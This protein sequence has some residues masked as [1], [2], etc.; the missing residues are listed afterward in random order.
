MALNRRIPQLDGLRGIAILSVF[1]YHAYNV[2]LMWMGVDL[3][4]VLSGF[5][6]TGILLQAKEQSFKSYIGRFYQRRAR[7]L[8]PGYVTVLAIIGVVFGTA[9]LKHW[10]LYFGLMNFLLP[11]HLANEAINPM[12]SLAVEEQFYF[13]WPVAVFFLSRKQLIRIAVCLLA[14][15]PILRW[16]CTPWFDNHWFVY[17][18]LPFR[19]DTL[20]AGALIALLKD[21]VVESTRRVVAWSGSMLLVAFLGLYELA[22]HHQM[23]AANT[24]ISN[25][26]IYEVTLLVATSFFLLALIGIAKP[27]L[28]FAPLCWLGAISYSFYLFHVTGLYVVHQH[29]M[30]GLVLTMAY[31][32][33]MWL[34]IEKPALN[35]RQV[36]RASQLANN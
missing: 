35:F 23:S 32:S 21:S 16:V 2:T 24:R 4:F 8:L 28:S 5:L 7:R 22:K 31:A 25:T 9:W 11:L 17:T 13:L 14:L 20:A 12:W 15:A 30:R 6:I 19:M 3:F 33:V 1:A 34:L 36:P 29:P 26:F 27:I 18:Q 10:Y